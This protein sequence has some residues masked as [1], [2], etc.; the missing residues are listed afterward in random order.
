VRSPEAAIGTPQRRS[1][2]RDGHTCGLPLFITYFALSF[3]ISIC[4][5]NRA[6]LASL[7]TFHNMLAK[8]TSKGL[9]GLAVRRRF[10]SSELDHMQHPDDGSLASR[11]PS[12]LSTHDDVTVLPSSLSRVSTPEFTVP[13]TYSE[14][15]HPQY[16]DD[17][18]PSSRS[19]SQLSAHS[20]AVVPAVVNSKLG[21]L[22]RDT[23]SDQRAAAAESPASSLHYE[24]QQS[25]KLQQQLQDR[26]DEA[27]QLKR[28]QSEVQQRFDVLEASV[29]SVLRPS[30]E[31][32]QQEEAESPAVVTQLQQLMGGLSQLFS[33]ISSTES[34]MRVELLKQE[35][36][37]V[38]AEQE[39]AQALAD[40]VA[41]QRRN[42]ELEQALDTDGTINGYAVRSSKF[43]LREKEL[44]AALLELK[45]EVAERDKCILCLMEEMNTAAA[46]HE[47]AVL[48]STSLLHQQKT[49]NAD[50]ERDRQRV[51]QVTDCCC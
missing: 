15:G 17:D 14:A 18:N 47:S 41:L 5:I 19:P 6:E 35:S 20:D 4:A 1:L 42:A 21:L 45:S 26:D 38:M 46:E 22:D 43:S 13:A 33:S 25:F 2:T 32:R 49:L 27:M 44:E 3:I 9:S 48:L 10:T 12:Q 7:F 34:R 23:P 8:L 31:Q 11:S 28:L 39:L 51:L 40:I 37:S 30:S 16:L 29:S 36:T 24:R 50:I